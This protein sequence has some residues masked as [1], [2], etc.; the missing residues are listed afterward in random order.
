MAVVGSMM[1]CLL[2]KPKKHKVAQEGAEGETLIKQEEE[3]DE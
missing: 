2:K 1:F 3:K